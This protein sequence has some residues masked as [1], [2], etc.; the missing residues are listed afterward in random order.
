MKNGKDGQGYFE[1]ILQVDVPKSR[2]GKH[3]QIVERLL[4]EL[5]ELK[6]GMAMKVPLSELPDSKENIR[7]ALTRAANQRQIRI[8]T[9]SNDDHLFV[10]KK[11]MANGN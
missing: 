10:W 11:H 8:A 7:S 5:G 6:P 4:R 9:S 1:S 3:K 2:D